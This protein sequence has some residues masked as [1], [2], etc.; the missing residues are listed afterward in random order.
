VR[1]HTVFPFLSLIK[2]FK[3]L[4]DTTDAELTHLTLL[5]DVWVLQH[6]AAVQERACSDGRME[7]WLAMDFT[8]R[9]QSFMSRSL[10]KTRMS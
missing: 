10:Q 3:T 8:E 1:I 2:D 5:V 7:R 4:N 9:F 6:P